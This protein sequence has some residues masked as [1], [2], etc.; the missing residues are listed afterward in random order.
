VHHDVLQA[1]AIG[2]YSLHDNGVNLSSDIDVSAAK[3]A[4][5]NRYI[6]AASN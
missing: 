1:D 3:G 6:T 5:H 4:S 2:S